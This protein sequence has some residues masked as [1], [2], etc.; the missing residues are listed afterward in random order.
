M[1]SGHSPCTD[2]VM[3]WLDGSLLRGR[4]ELQGRISWQESVGRQGDAGSATRI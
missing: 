2:I 4:R 3:A 1:E